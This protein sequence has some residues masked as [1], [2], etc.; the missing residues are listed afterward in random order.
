MITRAKNRADRM[1]KRREISYSKWG[2]K[3]LANII[4]RKKTTDLSEVLSF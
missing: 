4:G 2:T 3:T 1:G